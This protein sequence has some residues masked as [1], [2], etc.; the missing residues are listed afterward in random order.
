MVLSITQNNIYATVNASITPA[1]T[2]VTTE[3]Y[4]SI[5]TWDTSGVTDMSGL[6][7]GKT[8]FNSDISEWNVSNV[9]NMSSMFSGATIF[10]K[11]ISKWSTGNVTNMN[12]M[13]LDASGFNQDLRLW[14]TINIPQV[15][16]DF[17][18]SAT[19][20][21]E[22]PRWG[23]YRLNIVG[24]RFITLF[25]DSPYT[26]AGISDVFSLPITTTST[27][28]TA[29]KG[30]YTVEYSVSSAI[31]GLSN[32]S[33][34]I[35][36]VIVTMPELIL[37]TSWT[38]QGGD[39]SIITD[40]SVISCQYSLD[41]GASW[42]PVASTGLFTLVEKTY[43]INEVQVKCTDME[44]NIR[45][46]ANTTELYIDHTGPTGLDVTFPSSTTPT[47]MFLVGRGIVNVSLP[48]DA[49]S[50]K[51]SVN[52]GYSWKTIVRDSPNSYF[53]LKEG[54]YTINAIQVICT[55]A[56]GN[57]SDPFFNGSEIILYYG[58]K[59]NFVLTALDSLIILNESALIEGSGNTLICD[60]TINLT[61]TVPAVDLQKTF[62]YR[63]GANLPT[64]IDYYVDTSNWN[65]FQTTL[66]PKNGIVGD[67]GYA[68]NDGVG[69]DFLR[70]LAKQL[71]GTYIGADL[72]TNEDT[73]VSEINS[74]CDVITGE[75]SNL[76]KHI[77]LNDGISA[78]LQMDE[79]NKKFLSDNVLSSS[80]ISREIF[81]QLKNRAPWRFGD[82]T[83][84]IYNST[85]DGFY[86]LPILKDD[87]FSFKLTI[88]PADSQLRFTGEHLLPRTY[89]VV[90]TVS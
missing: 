53:L 63:M 50:W 21:T 37:S 12:S 64:Y 5:T 14:E 30:V 40:L 28:N 49:V 11:D 44:G 43:A 57:D 68:A 89:K 4:G 55:D 66:N 56:D 25:Q 76:L 8:T 74:S 75:I 42:T 16:L 67:G 18:T 9:T 85:D 13:F 59:V 54:T 79:F 81:N 77:D 17:A 38:T 62:F 10:N 7:L 52:N 86:K 20:F 65:D 24:N 41:G 34:A 83:T 87:T 1:T 80:N 70:N 48:T 39:I 47:T 15:P 33:Y 69:K 84:Y 88:H 23:N 35:R 29:V 3:N 61:T 6:F 46:I 78:L 26:D 32:P 72:F 22:Y 82:L 73:I 2:A 45:I 27:V 90:L 60:A 19:N 36:Y 51:Y 71:F 31:T 58:P